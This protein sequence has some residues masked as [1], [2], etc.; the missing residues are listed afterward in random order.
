MHV[1]PAVVSDIQGLVSF[2]RAY[3]YE[4]LNWQHVSFDADAL[5]E[6]LR[7][8]IASPTGECFVLVEDREFLGFALVFL[9]RYFF[10]RERYASDLTFYVAPAARRG[11]A[12]VKLIR[13]MIAYAQ[14][15]NVR[16]LLL[17]VNSGV[18]VDRTVTLI[19]RLGGRALGQSMS[20]SL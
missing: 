2:C 20:I 18:K 1:R 14:S 3:A 17:T 9:N 12:G 10:S 4:E 11:W 7:H 5:A 19:E 16:E 15:H 6:T 8:L 13:A